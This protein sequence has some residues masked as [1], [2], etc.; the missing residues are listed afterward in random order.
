MRLLYQPV[1]RA[2][3]LVATAILAVLAHVFN[4]AVQ[5]IT[6]R[7]VNVK[8]DFKQFYDAGATLARGADPYRAFLDAPCPGQH[9]C[10]GGYIYPPLL[11][12]LMRPLAVLPVDAALRTWLAV[13]HL[14][15]LLA[16][17]LMW[18]ALRGHV[19][20]AVLSL[21]VI[22][23]VAFRPLQYTLYFAQVGLMLTAIL[24]VTVSRF[25]RSERATGAGFAAGT[26]AVLRVSPVL[27]LPSLLRRPRALAEAVVAAVVL[28]VGMLLLTPYTVEYFTTVLPRIGGSTGILDNQAPQGMVLRAAALWGWPEP[29]GAA[30]T[31]AVAL[32]VLVPTAFLALR[33]DGDLRWRGAVVAAFLAAMPLVSSLTWQHHLVTELL[34]YA[35]LAPA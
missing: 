9:W 29:S 7:G 25:M 18:R 15:L 20:A 26:A 22:A 31:A 16:A 17:V 30:V 11:A 2:R 10:L 4:G 23:T 24:A 32:V 5:L 8:Y 3:L 1:A 28:L 34:V 33:R 27:V 21:L 12:E 13:S 6:L 35:A 14:C 19:S